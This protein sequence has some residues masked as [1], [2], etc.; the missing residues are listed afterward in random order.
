MVTIPFLS[1]P[2]R[3]ERQRIIVEYVVGGLQR[4]LNQGEPLFGVQACQVRAVERSEIAFSTCSA[5]P[6]SM[7]TRGLWPKSMARFLSLSFAAGGGG[8]DRGGENLAGG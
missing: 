4:S 5:G 7:N 6:S 2:W 1:L 8:L 3:S